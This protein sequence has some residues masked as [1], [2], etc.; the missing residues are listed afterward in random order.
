MQIT[1]LDLKDKVIVT[2]RH[3]VASRNRYVY[4]PDHL[5][6][7]PTPPTSLWELFTTV[8]AE[9]LFKG[10]PMSILREATRS[11]GQW[12]FDESV[13]SFFSRRFGPELVNNIL[14]A[15][16]HGIYAGDVWKLSAKSI[17]PF[18]WHGEETHGGVLRAMYK[19]WE[20][21][22][23]NEAKTGSHGVV[24]QKADG[25]MI[26]E[27][28][29]DMEKL[30]QQSK[31]HFWTKP[32]VY[33]LQGGLQSL[34]EA[35]EHDLRRNKNVEIRANTRVRTVEPDPTT[36]GIRVRTLPSKACP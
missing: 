34:T 21:E 4:Y 12:K 2:P 14:S 25:E 10:I 13:G 11:K 33:A 7:L 19:M 5:V 28:R 16:C 29:N 30:G 23:E 3:S 24:V 26:L 31:A 22:I 9:P 17:F 18:A 1:Q 15:M 20:S 8:F 35:L 32:G 6:R 27:L 36:G